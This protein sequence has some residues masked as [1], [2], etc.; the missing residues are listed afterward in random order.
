MN[1]PTAAQR[2]L[3]DSFS[4]VSEVVHDSVAGIDDEHLVA[5]LSSTSNTIAW[6]IWHLTRVQDDH[7]AGLAGTDQ[8]W[9]TGGWEQRFGL[10]FEA[11]AV[12]YGQTSDEVAAVQASATDLIGYFDAVHDATT[13]YIAG[14]ADGDLQRI[15]DRNYDPPVTVEVRLVSVI[16]DCLQHAGQ[17]AFARGVL[18]DRWANADG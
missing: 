17:A 8:T 4:R 16:S 10:P 12:G 6:L 2:I 18:D 14:V 9:I 3:L 11:G 1:E 7:I 5:R 15:I 13:A